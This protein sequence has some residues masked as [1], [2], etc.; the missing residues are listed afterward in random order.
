M[1]SRSRK[2]NPQKA[3]AGTAKEISYI[4]NI[5]SNDDQT[6]LDS[7]DHFSTKTYL[8]TSKEKTSPTKKAYP[9]KSTKFKYEENIRKIKNFANHL[10]KQR[11]TIKKEGWN[12]LENFKDLLL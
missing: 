9:P 10:S 1:P 3:S 5:V 7:V 12:F 11:V 4:A 6:I 8:K 2:N